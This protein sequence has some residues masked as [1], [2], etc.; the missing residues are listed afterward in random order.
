M[1]T[2]VLTL[3]GGL[4]DGRIG[5]IPDAPPPSVKLVGAGQLGAGG[6]QVQYTRA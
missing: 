1:N 4:G 5:R 2:L 6:T 3:N